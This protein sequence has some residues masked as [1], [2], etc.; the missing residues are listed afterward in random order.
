MNHTNHKKPHTKRAPCTMRHTLTISMQRVAQARRRKS[1]SSGSRSSSQF[2]IF[3]ATMM[4]ACRASFA[5]VRTAGCGPGAAGN[6]RGA[7]PIRR[8]L[9]SKRIARLVVAC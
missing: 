9:T 1:S 4:L 3:A 2:L 7:S 6:L 8:F 5:F